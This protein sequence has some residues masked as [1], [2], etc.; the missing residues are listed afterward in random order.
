MAETDAQ[1]WQ[2]A[3]RCIEKRHH[4]PCY[5]PPS[6]RENCYPADHCEYHLVYMPIFHVTPEISH[7]K[8]RRRLPPSQRMHDVRLHAPPRRLL[9]RQQAGSRGH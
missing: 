5:R 3:R 8:Q 6:K 7:A 9:Q 4:T 1:A 2:H